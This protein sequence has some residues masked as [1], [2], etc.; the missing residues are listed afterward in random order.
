M[1]DRF[2]IH[3]D[4]ETGKDLRFKSEPSIPR[5]RYLTVDLIGDD[6][7]QTYTEVIETLEGPWPAEIRPRPKGFGWTLYQECNGHT[8][9]R[10]PHDAKAYSGEWHDKKRERVTRAFKRLAR[11]AKSSHP[12]NGRSR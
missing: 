6:I 4:E 11:N 2:Y 12:R 1:T 5:Y 10:R 3:H 8:V 9:W 7:G